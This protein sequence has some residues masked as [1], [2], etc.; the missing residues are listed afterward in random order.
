[1]GGGDFIVFTSG[2]HKFKYY[3]DKKQVNTPDFIPPTQRLD[4]KLEEF[5]RRLKNWKRGDDR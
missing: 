1:M 2:N 3:D 4:L 5:T